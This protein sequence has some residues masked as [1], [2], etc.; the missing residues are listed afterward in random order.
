MKIL[1]CLEPGLN[2]VFGVTKKVQCSVLHHNFSWI[3]LLYSLFFLG[4]KHI[5]LQALSFLLHSYIHSFFLDLSSVLV[6]FTWTFFV[7]FSNLNLFFFVVPVTLPLCLVPPSGLCHLQA[8]PG[9]PTRC[10]PLW[11]LVNQ[12]FIS[13]DQVN[14]KS[15]RMHA[16]YL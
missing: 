6:V 12:K 16:K 3:S 4:P 14:M 8:K 2:V 15:I 7:H 10:F 13:W 9:I 11:V 1:L 5:D